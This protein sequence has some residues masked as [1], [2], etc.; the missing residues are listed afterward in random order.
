VYTTPGHCSTAAATAARSTAP[1][2][3]PPWAP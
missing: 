1:P 3:K 2:S